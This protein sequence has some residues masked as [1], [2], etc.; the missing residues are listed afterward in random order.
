MRFVC[1][2]NSEGLQSASVFM[3]YAPAV[4]TALIIR[5]PVTEAME[6]APVEEL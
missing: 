4:A 1:F 6:I 2:R 3:S 5:A